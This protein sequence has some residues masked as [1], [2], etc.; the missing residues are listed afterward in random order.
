MKFRRLIILLTLVVA[1]CTHDD[2]RLHGT[3]RSNR[4]ATVAATLERDPR[5][6]KATP[7]RLQKFGDMFGHLTVTYSNGV[8][9]ADFSGKIETARYRVVDRG[10]DYVIIQSTAVMDKG[11]DIKIRF[12]DDYKAYWVHS[13]FGIDE[14]FDKVQSR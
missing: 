5:W 8:E 7:E 9:T 1:G 6:K 2:V 12:V 10:A 3:W 13:P 14:R 4:D 11:R